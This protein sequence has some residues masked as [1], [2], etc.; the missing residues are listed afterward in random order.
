MRI[1]RCEGR[2]AQYENP[3]SHA[4]TMQAGQPFV[5]NGREKTEGFCRSARD[6]LSPFVLALRHSTENFYDGWM[7]NKKSAMISC[8]GAFGPAGL[9]VNAAQ[10]DA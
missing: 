3:I 4:C 2:S 9:P 10:E 5:A 7:R 8:S 6:T 1:T